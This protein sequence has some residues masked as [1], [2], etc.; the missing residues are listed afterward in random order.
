MIV[1][2]VLL[3]Q[4]ALMPVFVGSA[5]LKHPADLKNRC[6]DRKVDCAIDNC[7]WCQAGMCM[8]CTT[9]YFL[10]YE[11]GA[12]LPCIDSCI[13]CFGPTDTDCYILKRGFIFNG[14][15]KVTPTSIF[16]CEYTLYQDNDIEKEYCAK[17]KEG[18]H[19]RFRDDN[20]MVDSYDCFKC[21]DENCG[22][23]PVSEETC[24]ACRSGYTLDS[25]AKCIQRVDGCLVYDPEIEKCTDCPVGQVWSYVTISC[26]SCPTE[27]IACS[28]SGK[29]LGCKPGHFYQT[30]TM[31]CT[32][33][34][35][36]GCQNC[37]DGAE[38]CVSCTPGKHFDLLRLKCMN[39]HESC[40]TCVGP[41]EEDC[42]HC[43][44][45][46]KS[47]E[48][49]F[50]NFD[51]TIIKFQLQAFR[52]KFP[53]IMSQ[54]YFM[55]TNFHP[56]SERLCVET[57]RDRTYYGEKFDEMDPHSSQTA[58]PTV[59]VLHHLMSSKNSGYYSSS[60]SSDPQTV[61]RAEEAKR[62]RIVKLRQ[63]Q[64]NILKTETDEDNFENEHSLNDTNDI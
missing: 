11:K 19:S 4:V 32:P 56:E 37:G 17:C 13:R 26:V 44:V 47:Q 10:D 1:I 59:K 63:G 15:K 12:C 54:A 21:A 14:E 28:K 61:E 40:G 6:L 30:E 20:K 48:V 52:E 3:C 38:F 23:C 27:C 41:K 36:P 25:K 9:G 8:D 22:N 33:C 45:G 58:C 46:R 24:R 29:C 42:G 55:A 39:C 35:V 53:K 31:T 2:F 18:Y 60:R 34:L 49:S 7:E 43:R 64:D 5:C 50:S 57:C 62:S 16:G 51:S